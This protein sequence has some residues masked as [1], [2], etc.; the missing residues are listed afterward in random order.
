MR[1]DVD[2]DAKRN[3][4]VVPPVHDAALGETSHAVEIAG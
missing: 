3:L 4:W 2:V 1:A